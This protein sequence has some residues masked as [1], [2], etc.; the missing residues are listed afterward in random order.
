MLSPTCI[1]APGIRSRRMT[2]QRIKT[3]FAEVAVEDSGGGGPALL[4]IH[5]NSASKAVFAR[6]FE[7]EL[8]ARVRMIAFDLPGHGASD[9]AADPVAAYTIGGYAQ[10]AVDVLEALGARRAVVFGWSLGGHVAVDMLARA[11]DLAGV[12]IC[13]TPPVPA[14]PEG[15]SLGFRPSPHMALT[16]A[17]EWSPADAEAFAREGAQPFEP[18]ML[19]DALRTD[20]RARATMLADALAGGAGDQRR[21]AE[22]APTP[23]A[24]VNG[25]DDAFVNTDYLATIAYANLWRGQVFNLPGLGHA[26]FWQAPERFNPLLEQFIA[27]VSD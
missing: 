20:G 18:F 4:M 22:T 16:G 1:S 24:I 7:S 25:A 5:G 21:I 2:H 17:A 6:Q 27:D 10:T 9:D 14:G 13:G 3:R 15:L 23:L 12:M 8:A 11:P 26:P 19:D